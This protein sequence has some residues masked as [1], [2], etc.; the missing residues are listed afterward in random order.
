MPGGSALG[1]SAAAGPN[2]ASGRPSREVLVDL[3]RG[4]PGVA[5]VGSGYVG[6]VVAACLAFLG[7]QVVGVETDPD[8]LRDLA[9]GRSPFYEPGLSDLLIDSVGSGRL[10]F[11]DDMAEAVG[12]SDVIFL[13]V[14]TPP[15]P[16]GH[17]DMSSVREAAT[18]IGGALRKPRVLVTK[19]TVPI[20]SGHWL[21]A[22]VEDAYDG[23]VP[24]DDLLS[25]VSCPEFL[26]EGSAVADFLTPE[27]VVLGS[28]RDD[29]VELIRDV[30]RPVLEQSFPGGDP[31]RRPALV[32]TG[33]LT[34]ETV[35]YASNAFLATKISFINEMATICE[36]VGADVVE[37]A[38]AIGLDSRIGPKFL[39]AGAGWGGSCFGKDLLELISTAADYGHEPL[40]L[41]AVSEINA[42]QRHTVVEKLRRHL[43]TMRGRR[44]CL[45]GLAFKPGTADLRDAPALDVARW[46][47]DAGASVRAHDPLVGSVPDLPELCREVDVYE[48]ARGADAVVVMTEWPDYVGIDVEELLSVMRGRLL[49]DGRNI[50]DPATMVGRGFVY[51]GVGRVSTGDPG[52]AVTGRSALL[53][54]VELQGSTA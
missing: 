1:D 11:T 41:K 21:R 34:A 42:R 15:G 40:L 4:L 2:G 52:A 35:K 32:R 39:D 37:V 3:R 50:F 29:A 38:T 9:A 19:S 43:K 5:V 10:S 23:S 8:K 17:A 27:R 26:R 28:D 44:I 24:L 7:R 14:G 49:I 45:L 51:E 47:L 12:R 36:L 22:V 13:C 20:G 6:T 16:G 18:A 30:Y 25:V 54:P 31:Q 46:L 53:E 33:L 48:A